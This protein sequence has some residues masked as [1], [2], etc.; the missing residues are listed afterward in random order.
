MADLAFF[1][2]FESHF[3]VYK[4]RQL[5]HIQPFGIVIFKHSFQQLSYFERVVL[6]NHIQSFL[7]GFVQD[8]KIVII[9]ALTR[10]PQTTNF[11]QQ[12]SEHE[13]VRSM[14]N[15]I[16]KL[17]LSQPEGQNHLWCEVS[18]LLSF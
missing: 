11:Q 15:L 17:V 10:G 12:H 18:K 16:F 6:S 9:V 2:S 7:D 3:L 1:A 4:K 14:E 13:D 8:V 5:L